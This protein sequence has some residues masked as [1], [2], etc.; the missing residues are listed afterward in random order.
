MARLYGAIYEVPEARVAE[1]GRLRGEA[2]EARDRGATADPE[3]PQARGR[4]YWP[5]VAHL[6]RASYRELFEALAVD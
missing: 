4:S 2:A 1:A 5:E 6:L 3:G